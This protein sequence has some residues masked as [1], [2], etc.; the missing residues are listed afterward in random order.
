MCVYRL[1]SLFGASAR[2]KLYLELTVHKTVLNFL[3]EIN[4]YKYS[5]T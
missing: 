2:G 3:V 4:L 1:T 5:V